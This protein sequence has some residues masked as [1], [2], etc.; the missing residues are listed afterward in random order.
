MDTFVDMDKPEAM[1]D[2]RSHD[3]GHLT[4]MDPRW[5]GAWWIG[6]TLAMLVSLFLG[7]G[8]ERKRE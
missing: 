5:C 1:A 4:T 7:A 2:F 6:F 8:R 3:A